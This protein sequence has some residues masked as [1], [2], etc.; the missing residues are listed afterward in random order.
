MAFVGFAG[1]VEGGAVDGE[2]VG[3]G[4]SGEGVVET[5]CYVDLGETIILE[6]NL[7]RL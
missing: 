2:G 7:R 5:E 6:A 4:W 1:K 3:K